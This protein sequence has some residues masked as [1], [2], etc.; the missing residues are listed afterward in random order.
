MRALFVALAILAAAAARGQSPCRA[1]EEKGEPLAAI[2]CYDAELKQ[3]TAP[4]QRTWLLSQR[5]W[6]HWRVSQYE[7]AL[8]D[9]R[10]VLTLARELRDRTLEGRTISFI[11]LLYQQI[12]ETDSALAHYRQA[13]PIAREIGDP[14]LTGEVLYHLG[15]LSFQEGEFRK[16]LEHYADS[17]RARHEAGDAFGEAVTLLG[18]SKS[19]ASLGEGERALQHANDAFVIAE[20]I[21]RRSVQADAL[22]H[23]GIALTLLKRPDEA[24]GNHT[25]AL[26]LR[27]ADGATMAISTSLAGLARAQH[28]QG[29]VR[30]AVATMAELIDLIEGGRRNVATRRF[31]GSL[32]ARM[33]PHYDRYLAWLMELGDE[34]TAFAASERA[35]ARLTVDSVQEALARADA[36]A[37]GTL[38]QRE[39]ALQNKIDRAGADLG[40]L[41]AQLAEIEEAIRREYPRLAAARDRMPLDA[42]EVQ[43]ELPDRDIAVVEFSLAGEKAFAWVVTRDSIDGVELPRPRDIQSLATR[44]HTALSAGDRRAKRHEIESLLERLRSAIVAPLPLPR[45]SKLLIVPDGALF[46]VPFAALLDRYEITMAPS[47]TAAL[48]MRKAAEGRTYAGDVAIF[49]DPVFSADDSRVAG[50]AV[51]V[52]ADPELVRSAAAAGLEQW[53]RLPST[54]LEAEAISRLVV[55][56]KVRK[57]LDFDASRSAVVRGNLGRFRVA[58]FATHAL[59]HSR[60]PELS[61]IVLSLVDRRG[62]PVSGFLRVHDLYVLD[63]SS[64]LVVLSACR[65]AMG[66]ELR[67]E[68]IVGMVNGFMHAGTAR[69]VA[70]YW[71]VRDEAT[72]E[73]MQRFYRG[74]FLRGLAPA[75]ALR[76]AQRSMRREERWK[77]PYHWAA[78]A[79]WGAP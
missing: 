4:R 15:W 22:D 32:F 48:L 44:L 27:R 34:R 51:P 2:A 65:T 6:M 57:S 79:V 8:A 23:I 70:S 37:G 69:V 25:R 42:G 13:L 54:R 20:R 7:H 19:H 28:A 3:T 39:Q 62:A 74:M 50:K 63:V 9:F 61:G 24:I 52:A 5:A 72:S 35:R 59:I 75:A 68:G 60:R 45:V 30:E 41:L 31:R 33:R 18:L 26:E 77:S 14:K 21:G 73:L 11:G 78:F 55:S 56:G 17:L 66:K 10:Q 76:E 12:G 71:D 47:A 58:H 40:E 1:L 43:A 67:G 53:R 38:L 29:R 46:Y 36:A 16:S 64:D 49:A